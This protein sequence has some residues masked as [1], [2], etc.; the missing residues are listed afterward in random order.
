MPTDKK[1]NFPFLLKQRV[2]YNSVGGKILE[3]R[4]RK[5]HVLKKTT[6][7]RG[8]EGKKER[9]S[10]RCFLLFTTIVGVSHGGSL[11]KP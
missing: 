3:S 11:K 2:V 8:N 5:R 4:R 7:K 1:K 10:A 6:E 9:F